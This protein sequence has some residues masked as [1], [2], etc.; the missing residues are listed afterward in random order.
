MTNNVPVFYIFDVSLMYVNSF[1][2]YRLR[3]EI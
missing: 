3:M 1:D 2:C